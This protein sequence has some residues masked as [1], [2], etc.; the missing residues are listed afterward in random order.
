MPETKEQTLYSAE[1]TLK[2][3]EEAPKL[4]KT[5]EEKDLLVWETSERPFKRRNRDFYITVIAM[6]GIVGLVLFLVEGWAPVILIVSLVFLFYVMS[7][8]EPGNVRYKIT[9][10]GVT[11]GNQKT[12]PFSNFGRF[13]FTRRFDSDLLVF[14]TFSFPGRLEIVIDP[15]VKD[16]ALKVLSKY[17]THE[18]VPPSSLDKAAN[19]FSKKLPQQEIQK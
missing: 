18:E 1:S 3:E 9:N 6:A 5:I 8:I 15:T 10:K 13:W 16:E 19:W 14:E 12:T 17:L 11:V 2:N 7:T 4:K